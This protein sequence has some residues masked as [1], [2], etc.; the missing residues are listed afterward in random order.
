MLQALF[1]MTT[2][3]LNKLISFES[4]SPLV[5]GVVHHGLMELAPRLN[6]PLSQLD[7]VTD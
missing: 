4:C 2:V 3:C 1:E 5:N 6:Q 7:H